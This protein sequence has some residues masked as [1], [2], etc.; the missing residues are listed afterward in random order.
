[1]GDYGRMRRSL[2]ILTLGA[3][4]A[5]GLTPA[6]AD[7]RGTVTVSTNT[8]FVM[9]DARGDAGSYGGP[10]R[11]ERR[12]ADLRRVDVRQVGNSGV[13]RMTVGGNLRSRAVRHWA[14]SASLAPRET[15]NDNPWVTVNFRASAAVTWA[16]YNNEHLKCRSEVR[17]SNRGRTVTTE[18]PHRCTWW[19]PR[20]V[21][22]GTFV[23]RRD[24]TSAW[25]DVTGRARLAWQ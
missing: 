24:G 10:T 21:M 8:K 13:V 2:A 25:D 6:A 20:R 19:K 22:A 9:R 15:T 11:A 1:M 18:I 3:V 4:L 12:A 7:R 16:Y 14:I 23:W 17:I 5:A